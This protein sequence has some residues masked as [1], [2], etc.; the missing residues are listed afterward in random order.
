M[1][2]LGKFPGLV[3]AR[4]NATRSFDAFMRTT[5][6]DIGNSLFVVMGYAELLA[7]SQ[8]V[9]RED[10]E[11]LREAGRHSLQLI[12]ETMRNVGEAGPRSADVGSV[13]RGVSRHARRLFRGSSILVHA[14]DGPLAARCSEVQLK[15][16]LL[17]VTL[18][19][20]EAMGDEG[21][22]SIS[23][24]RVR[25]NK[26]ILIEVCD[27]GPGF[28]EGTGRRT[29]T[30]SSERGFGLDSVER[31]VG[32]AGGHLSLGRSPAGGAR[33]SIYLPGGAV[34]QLKDIDGE[35]PSLFGSCVL[36]CTG[37]AGV[38]EALARLLAELGAQ[39]TI[40]GSPG[41]LLLAA[42]DPRLYADVL[43][44][45]SRTE[46]IDA[47]RLLRRFRSLQPQVRGFLR[48]DAVVPPE[49][50]PDYEI[51]EEPLSLPD[52]ARQIAQAER[53]SVSRVA[54]RSRSKA[55]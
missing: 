16:A 21:E 1:K 17:N 55:S 15:R 9:C 35:L 33:V 40:V 7:R 23:A 47:P 49:P 31:F 14:P 34:S 41:D 46:W 36:L 45:T 26:T 44:C 32:D 54:L 30:K 53:V 22:V 5:A 28:P 50:S 8:G 25:K 39:V 18:N 3:G 37:D 20:L 11:A 27:N 24:Q 10:A 38:D 42:E 29:S 19:A 6:H 52:V 51:L 4:G 13:V 48:A 2:L 43:I 12:D